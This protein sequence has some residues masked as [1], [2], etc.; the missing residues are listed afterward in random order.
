MYVPFRQANQVLPVYNLSMVVRAHGD[1]MVLSNALRAVIHHL[2]PNQP[3]IRVRTMEENVAASIAQPRLRTLL[4]AIFAAVALLIAA[5]GIY[6]VMSYAI[7][8]RSREMG[9]RLALGSSARGIFQLVVGEAMRLAG[10]GIVLGA[11]AALMAGA[12]VKSLLFGVP[13]SDLL[14][15][16]ASSAVVVCAALAASLGPAR[17]AA[18]VT[19]SETLREN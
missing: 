17:R 15:L 10:T 14:S 4:L 7:A 18:R 16:V 5:V 9:I 6:G 13:A 8:Q 12:Y 19:I 2:N 3:V 11:V 1:P